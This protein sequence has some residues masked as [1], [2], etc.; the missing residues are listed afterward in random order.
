MLIAQPIQKYHHHYLT[1]SL[2]E[3]FVPD[4]EHVTGDRAEGAVSVWAVSAQWEFTDGR[5]GRYTGWRWAALPQTI[6]PQIQPAGATAHPP[7][8]TD[9]HPGEGYATISQSN[10]QWQKSCPRTEVNL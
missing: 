8:Q 1:G 10:I 5:E 6:L 7:R 3:S 2:T 9:P 4:L